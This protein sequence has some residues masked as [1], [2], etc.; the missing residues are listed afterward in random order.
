[1]VISETEKADC[2]PLRCS[3]EKKE[4]NPESLDRRNFFFLHF[5]FAR[6][7]YTTGEIKKKLPIFTMN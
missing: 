4:V 6:V 5:K 7:F 3:R 1:M 2:T